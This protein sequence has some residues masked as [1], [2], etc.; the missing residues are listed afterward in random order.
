MSKYKGREL[1]IKV[2]TLLV[3]MFCGCWW[4]SYRVN[5]NQ[6]RTVDVT[7]KDGNGGANC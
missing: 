2:R 1:R 7:D 3:P 4:Y 5:D 6:F